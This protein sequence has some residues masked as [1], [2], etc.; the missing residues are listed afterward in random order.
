MFLNP[1]ARALRPPADRNLKLHKALRR[2]ACRIA[3]RLYLRYLFF[4]FYL[5]ALKMSLSALKARG[6]FLRRL[7][8]STFYVRAHADLVARALPTWTDSNL[9]VITSFTRRRF[10]EVFYKSAGALRYLLELYGR[11]LHPRRPKQNG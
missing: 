9:V 6:E 2:A 8:N 5:L 11:A 1:A 7:H 4:E 3:L 10:D